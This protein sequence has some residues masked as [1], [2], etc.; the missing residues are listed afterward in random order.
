MR[1]SETDKDTICALSTAHGI[2]AISVVRVS[3]EQAA[4]VVRKLAAFLPEHLESHKIYYGILKSADGSRA[5]D[6]VLISYFAKGRSFTGEPVF[7]ISCHGSESVVNDILR[8]LVSA[9]ARPA[10]RGEFTYR[11]FMGGRLDLVQAESVLALIESRSSR[12]SSLAL[13][14]LQGE[15]SKRLKSMLDKLTWVLAHLEANIDFA[16][17]DIQI[18][19]SEELVSRIE[20]LHLETRR[21]V[22]SYNQGRIVREGFQVA[23][24]GRPNAG[25]SSLLNALAGEERAIV[26]PVPGTTRDFVEAELSVS[27]LRVTLVDT[28][29][30][31]LSDDTVEKIGIARTLTKIQEADAVWYVSD[32]NEEV[33]AEESEFFSSIP[34]A[35]ALWIQNKCDLGGTFAAPPGVEP[36]AQFKVSAVKGTGLGELRA[37]LET[38]LK[39][40]VSEDSTLVSN[41]RHYR[42]LK[43]L[44]ASLE[45]AMPLV[46]MNESPDLIAL[47]LQTGLMAL[48][49]ILGLTFDDQVMDQVFKEFCLGK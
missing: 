17:E 32:S 37:W 34:W 38:R 4:A 47:E 7:E 45:K 26:T 9:G 33:S 14:Q 15:F 6:E 27:G 2:G 35:R 25:K 46:A 43:T 23:L 36:V 18:A 11:A 20:S 49:E 21:L 3:G 8:E 24:V 44:E 30:L 13:R 29:G 41:A 48:Y 5:V 40:E 22:D 31:R 1:H 28:A 19:G 12:A 10:E 16:S 39:S 42:G